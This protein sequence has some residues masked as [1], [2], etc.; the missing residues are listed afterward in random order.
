MEISPQQ[1]ERVKELY[2]AALT[3]DASQRDQV[4]RVSA[5]DS[6]ILDEVRRL[7]AEH[8]GLGSFLSTT[9]LGH[10]VLPD[11][12]PGQ[13]FIP[14][15]VLARR[16]RI[17][18][19]IAAGGMGEVYE[20][21]DLTL[22]ENLA[23]KTI[24]PGILQ[25]TSALERFKQ[26]VHL[27]RQVTHPNV[28]R[29][30]DLFNHR[31][32]DG[33]RETVFVSMELLQGE[34]LA[35]HIRRNGRF[36]A[37]E[38]IPLISQIAAGLHAAHR[39]GVVHGDLKPG[40]VIL[41]PDSQT[42]ETRCV[43]T[44][45]GLAIATE[46]DATV[47]FESPASRAFVGT[48]AYMA[49]EQVEGK[50]ATRFTDIYALGLVIY[51][52]VTGEHAF[53]ADTPL[54]SAVKRLSGSVAS[55]RTYVPDLPKN[56][57][58]TIVRCLERDPAARFPSASDVAAELAGRDSKTERPLPVWKRPAIVLSLL[59][60]IVLGAFSAR[61][62]HLRARERW[63]RNQVLPQIAQLTDQEHLDEAYALAVQAER[64]IPDDP[65]LKKTWPA[66]SWSGSLHSTPSGA[67]V[68]RRNYNSPGSPWTLV[69]RT[70]IEKRRFPLVDSQWKFELPGHVPVERA[71][72]P[73][74][75]VN[76]TFD[77]EDKA[78]EGMVRVELQSSSS[79]NEPI[80]LWGLAGF[81][82]LPRIALD[83][84]WIDKYE[85][86]NRQFRRFVDAGGYQKPQYWKHQFNKDGHEL[87]W[88]E[89]MEMFRDKTGRPG[90]AS[91][92]QGESPEGEADLPVTGVSWYEAAAYAEFAGKS[93]PSIYHWVAA[94][95]PTDS[96]SI[97][98][99]SNF[100]E[101]QLARAGA[102]SGMSWAGEYDMAGNVKEWVWNEAGSDRRYILGG[103]W[104]EPTYFFND[105]DARP[106]FERSANFGFRCVSYAANSMADKAF[107]PIVR[108][109]RDFSREKPVSEQ[110][111][112]AYKSLYS[113]DKAP[114]D[115]VVEST[116][117]N[118]E[119]KR[120]KV[121]FTA[122]YGNE[123][124]TAYLFLPVRGSPPY[125]AVVYFPGAGAVRTRS[126]AN[127]RPSDAFE[128][129]L[130]SGRAVMFP[131]YKATFERGDALKYAFP[132]TSSLYRDHVIA[133]SKDLGRSIDYLET[134]PDIDHRKLAYEGSSWGASMA[135]V[136][137]AVEDRFKAAV[138][139]D[140][141]FYLQ[142]CLPEADQLNFAPH[143]RVPV[144]M[145]NGRFDFIY[146]P[147]LSQE[148]MFR[149]LGT[150]KSKKRRVVYDTSHSL[151]PNPTIK[152]TLDWLD[153][154]LG[155]AR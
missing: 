48:P 138:L 102:Y 58:Q 135:A 153:K 63:A 53:P 52:V 15:Q 24:R 49:P 120:E 82:D 33:Q 86:T 87:S 62:I 21:E 2:E 128:F 146:P 124:M 147:Q 30:F 27:A 8:D 112:A 154:Y 60:L 96:A 23:I 37:S 142:R 11:R 42:N 110:L 35:E 25:D 36:A 32:I 73:D 122:A 38:A 88:S 19:F 71:T 108:E 10:Y 79:G 89:A 46:V 54:G 94:A 16:F 14:G 5:T 150:D 81:D 50:E 133:W 85:V 34:T 137:L 93:L 84:F 145:L 44:D 103:A 104:N 78:H 114:L 6:A 100:S 77:E 74:D 72:F 9:V 75:D 13:R 39:A 18:R 149:F 17:V 144:L 155:P 136:F 20:A 134:R 126:S 123:R 66:I 55:P 131:I 105:A 41:V 92:V 90:P 129:I 4:L 45:F 141:G 3:C 67:T 68:F 80:S 31:D 65:A 152:E 127:L 61:L 125:Q 69:G 119:W 91:W 64:I 1:W 121:S 43:I 26:E 115:A 116:E 56:W 130:R 109:T 98:P 59:L 101:K 151:P 51:E 118:G 12:P 40:N 113:Y 99:A 28:C 143:L 139:L 47:D 148:P 29:V 111:F 22:G 107:E 117:Q 70:P 76:V 97:I 95:S 7:L 140:P 106:S 57:E 83:S 132:N